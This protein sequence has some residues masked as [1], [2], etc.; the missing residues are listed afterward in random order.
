ML[1]FVETIALSLITA[2][3]LLPMA[4]TTTVP[5]NLNFI[6]AAAVNSSVFTQFTSSLAG[7]DSPKQSAI[8]STVWDWWYF[9][10]VGTD[11]LTSIIVLFSL[12][13]NTGFIGGSTTIVPTVSISGTFPNG[14]GYEYSASA[15][16]GA[17]VTTSP[18]GGASGNWIGTGFSW[19]GSA[20]MSRYVITINAPA[21]GISGT[22]T[23]HSK[24]PP[25]YPCGPN[26][27]GSNLA[28]SSNIGWANAIPDATTMVDL[29]VGDTHLCYTGVGYHD[30][31]CCSVTLLLLNDPK[32]S[33]PLSILI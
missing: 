20:D 21:A 33:S 11:H 18:E 31:V 16:G 22:I 4:L 2:L 28:I 17:T 13:L 3:S 27:V 6:P 19:V 24:A 29:Q 32:L 9:D 8:N 7:L 1:S 14:T 26:V 15:A 30:K 25:H 12:G 5:T 10:V 23:L